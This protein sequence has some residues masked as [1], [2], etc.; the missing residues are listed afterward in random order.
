MIDII[1]YAQAGQDYGNKLI[2]FEQFTEVKDA[3]LKGDEDPAQAKELP[4]QQPTV[5]TAFDDITLT[6]RGASLQISTSGRFTDPDGH[7]ITMIEAA[8]SDPNVATVAMAADDSSLTVTGGA[9]GTATI[10]VT[11]HDGHNGR[12]SDTFAVKVKAAP[13]VAS[14]LADIGPLVVGGDATVDLSG[15]FAD[16][17]GDTLTFAVESSDDFVSAALIQY[18][19]SPEMWVLTIGRGTAELTV[20]AQDSDGN[21]VSDKFAVTVKEAPTVANPIADIASL[22]SATTKL[23]SLSGVFADADGDALTLSAASSDTAVATVSAQP[24]PATGSVTAITVTAVSS[25]TATITVTARDSDGNS[26]ADTFDVTVPAVEAQQQAAAV[27]GPVIDLTLR[28]KNG[29]V[30][31]SWQPPEAGAAPTRYIVHLRPDGGEQGSGKTKR[32]KATKTKV[33]YRNLEPGTTYQV[34]VRAQNALGKGERVHATITLP[35]AQPE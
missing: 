2:T 6:G 26:V 13:T 4:N 21:E 31:V 24:D 7:T 32:P 10:T 16:T 9:S 33:T 8:S 23:I 25:G 5:N 11:A 18:T 15:V 29:G 17:D 3:W 12:V 14:P 35:Q 34:W 1:E 30:Q 20:T 19:P 22:D 28:L 27:P